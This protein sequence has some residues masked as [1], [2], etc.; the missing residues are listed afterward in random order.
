MTPSL[1]DILEPG[2]LIAGRLATYEQRPEQL[3]MARAVE[4]ALA[5]R[6]HLLAE[7]GTGVGKSFAYLIPAIL[8]AAEH[9]Q[10]VVL[11]TYTI[12]LQEQ[13][14]ARD[15]PFLADVLPV[16]FSAALGKGR[17]NYLCPRRLAVVLKNPGK[18]LGSERQEA[19]LE[20][21]V[22]WAMQTDTGELQD[23]DFH[24]DPAVWAKARSD[25]ALC[26]GNQCAFQERCFLRA[27][28]QRL[29]EANLMVVNH[30]MLFADLPLPPGAK[31]LGQYDTVVMDEAHTVEHVASEQF[32]RSVS[33]FQ[34]T[35]LLRD[36]YN[37]QNN[38]GQL[39]LTGSDEAVDAV[40]HAQAVAESFFA[41]LDACQ[42]PAV[43]PNGR[44]IR[45]EPV[46]DTLTPALRAVAKQL[47]SARRNAHE[48]DEAH[49]LLG[50]E[51][52]ANDLAGMV[53]DI[54]R[55]AEEDHVYW[56]TRRTLQSRQRWVSLNS[57]PVNVAPILREHLFDAIRSVILTSATL[58]TTQSSRHGFE[59]IRGRLGVDEVDEILLASPFDYRNQAT[60]YLETRLGNPNRL[61]DFA[62]HAA[63][64]IEHYL[65]QSQ[66]RCFVLC[67]SYALVDALADALADHCAAEGYELLVQG[68][69]LQRSAMLQRFRD[70]EGAV[71]VGTMS[72]WQG[73]DVAGANLSNVVIVK[74][75]FAVPDAPVTEARIEAIRNAG[76][77]P[78]SDF[79][80]PQAVILFKQGFGRLIRSTTDT[81]FVVVL[82][83][84]IVTKSYGRAFLDALPD[85]EIVRD[86]FCRSRFA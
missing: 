32:G 74:L 83:H 5:D 56:R 52:R 9:H 14:I 66:A 21:L 28:R 1:E 13:L 40:K 2:G 12:A 23:I 11:S 37:P 30:A 7:A 84:R 19:Q 51:L 50:Y 57:A 71:L 46:P 15:L 80:L 77:N 27:A 42:G 25:P 26:K 54:V 16:G 64:A 48:E 73:V 8:H 38:R 29:L 35:S 79:Q 18:L 75:P 22:D 70:S 85:I 69:S 20:A 36:L 3:A 17:G 55:L 63:A 76:G 67:T 78:F 39:A 6:R 41:A 60:L 33:S 24:L 47:K 34:V 68:R 58:A 81:G 49:E 53:D 82:D 62:P 72:F 43:A 44:L 4:S 59:Y 31:M 10:R 45:P 65:R 86:A 61:D